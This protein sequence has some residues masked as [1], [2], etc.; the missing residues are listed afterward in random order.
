MMSSLELA[1]EYCDARFERQ[2]AQNEH[3]KRENKLSQGPDAP[4][5]AQIEDPGCAYLPLISVVLE[6]KDDVESG[7]N[8]AIQVLS[9]RRNVIDRSAALHLIPKNIPVSALSRNFLIP[10]LIESDSQSKA[11]DDCF[12][13]VPCQIFT[14]QARIDGCSNKV[15]INSPWSSC[16]TTLESWGVDLLIQIIQSS[17]STFIS[18]TLPR[19]YNH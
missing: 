8:A 16:S 12:I 19:S 5:S 18:T 4:G 14:S 15:A 7:I 9:L 11:F 13:A 1:L 17:R 3:M 10:S 6:S 2:R